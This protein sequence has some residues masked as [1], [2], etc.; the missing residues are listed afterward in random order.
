M[1]KALDWTAQPLSTFNRLTALI[2]DHQGLPDVLLSLAEATQ[3]LSGARWGLITFLPPAQPAEYYGPSEATALAPLLLQALEQNP[4]PEGAP[5][6]FHLL[7]PKPTFLQTLVMPLRQGKTLLGILAALYNHLPENRPDETLIFLGNQALIAIEKWH[8]ETILSQTYDGTILALASAI[9]A[10]D[11]STHRHSQAVTELAVALAQAIQLSPEEVEQIRYAAILHDI[12]KIGIAES[13]L[14]KR[15]PLSPVERAVVEAHPLVGASILSGVP[16]MQELIPLIRHHHERCDGSGYP[17][18][19]TKDEIP[20]GS[21][22]LAIA[23]SFDAMTTERP[24]HQGLSIPDACIILE[25]EAGQLFHPELVA[26]FVR[27]IRQWIG[28]VEPDE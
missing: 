8:L 5:G 24:Y 17:D 16:H 20:F 12:G 4:L 2:A 10:R 15:G 26:V 9:D 1:S 3:E 6:V 19:L 25:K 7:L 13:I 11:P 28:E 21:L 18:G 27:M 14:S 23:D 22:I